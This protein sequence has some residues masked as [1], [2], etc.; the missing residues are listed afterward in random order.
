MSNPK[1]SAQPNQND[2]SAG[3]QAKKC[4]KTDTDSKTCEVVLPPGSGRIVPYNKG[5]SFHT[6]TPKSPHICPGKCRAQQ[7]ASDFSGMSGQFRFMS[8]QTV[9]TSEAAKLSITD[10][11]AR[12]IN[13][14][15]CL[16]FW[17]RNRNKTEKC[18]ILSEVG[19]DFIVIEDTATQTLSVIDLTPVHYINIY[20]P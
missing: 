11:L 15:V 12:F 8:A 3:N 17:H 10:Y 6:Y 14:Y 9:Q 16:D 2:T 18:G 7:R 13:M 5:K 20:C 19:K 4:S 1:T